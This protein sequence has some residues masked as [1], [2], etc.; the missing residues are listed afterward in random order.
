MIRAVVLSI[1]LV[2]IA[3]AAHADELSD[4][5]E[6][7]IEWRGGA[8]FEHLSSLE[9][10]AAVETAGLRGTQAVWA[11]RD[12]RLRVDTDLGVLK[13]SQV[14]APTGAWDTSPSGQVESLS[15]GDRHNLARDL[16]LQFPGFLRGE[17]GAAV[18]IGP[19]QKEDGHLWSVIR[20]RF[21]DE[22]IYDVLIDPMTGALGSL[23]ISED[24]KNR[25]ERFGDWRL[26]DGVRMPFLLTASADGG[27]DDQI[28][29][30][31]ALTINTSIPEERLKKPER[32]RKAV[33]KKGR[34]AIEWI[35]FE[36]FN[37]NRIFFPARINGLETVV[38]LDSGAS[39][40][41]VDK[42]FARTLGLESRGQFAAPGAGG[43]DTT[44]FVGAVDIEIG[45]MTLR[46]VNA[47]SFDFSPIAKRIGHP[48]P[49]VLGDEVFNE[50]AVDIDFAHRRLAFRDPDKL[51]RPD[52]AVEVPL[53]RI[54]DRA[55]PVSVEGAPPVFFEFDLGDGTPLDIYPSY[56]EAHGLLSG[57]PTSKLE[58]GG[59]GGYHAETV[60]TVRRI[61][62]AGVDLREVPTNFT[63]NVASAN[64]SNLLFGTVGLPIW[65]RFHLIIDYTHD[66]LFAAP[67]TKMLRAP[68][69]RD[70]F[71]ASLAR[72]EGGI[73]EV[74]FISPGGPAEA[75]GLR[76]GERITKIDGKLVA[77]WSDVAL[78]SLRFPRTGTEILLTTVDGT[79]HA[80]ACRDFF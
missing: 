43:V 8:A 63:P 69:A 57:R 3:P 24:R 79:T 61:T 7:Y 53:M 50:F 12:G 46:G 29:K 72:R 20:V 44:G 71:G 65:A 22:D 28:L 48:M 70:R 26:I 11:S 1:A 35:P 45:S 6:R 14:I 13:Q 36:F 67:D 33:F 19:Q 34:A 54:K 31:E 55:V 60:A 4:L 64:N 49:F 16:A 76:V 42:A 40:S 73:V 10:K 17:G 21:G 37:D 9:F 80:V 78:L 41:A 39:V 75:A 58:A 18:S 23:Q 51:K 74:T 59:V 62:I 56:Y 66:R 2:G 38:L 25:T 47:V 77:E 5:I 27:N 68:F 30:I 32:V 15:V 52:R